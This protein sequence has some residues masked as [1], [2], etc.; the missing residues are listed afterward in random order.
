MDQW[1]SIKHQICIAF[2]IDEEKETEPHRCFHT[3]RS[4]MYAYEYAYMNNERLGEENSE[5]ML[6][7][8]LGCGGT[9]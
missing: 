3:T 2:S 1:W 4:R 9:G 6:M 7:D 5:K 8:P